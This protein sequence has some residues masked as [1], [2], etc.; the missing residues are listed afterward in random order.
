MQGG[1]HTKLAF[2][3]T[4]HRGARSNKHKTCYLHVPIVLKS[5]TL[6]FLEPSGPVQASNG[7]AFTVDRLIVKDYVNIL[8]VIR[9]IESFIYPTDAQLYCSKNVKIYIEIYM[10]VAATCF[11]FSQPSSGS[12]CMCF[13]KVISINNQSRHSLTLHSAL[14]THTHTHHT[15]TQ[16]PIRTG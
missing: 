14:H 11:G 4:L 8:D 2:F 12:Y 10:R 7:F 3:T 6:N 16:I 5:R 9:R 15:H 13:A 1:M